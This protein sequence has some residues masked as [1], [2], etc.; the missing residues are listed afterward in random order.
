MSSAMTGV[1]TRRIKDKFLP[2]SFDLLSEVQP[3]EGWFCIVGIKGKGDVRQKLL[4]TRKEADE[5]IEQFVAQQR[6]VFF[7]VAKYKTGDNRTKS[8]VQAL[9]SL[10]VDIDC[11]PEKATP[12]PNTG[13]PAGYA[14]QKEAL[15]A[16][17]DFS[18]LVG[19]P[20]P[21]TVN[22]GCG[23]HAYWVLKEAVTREQWEPVA[24]KLAAVC[25]TQR[26]HVD[27]AVFEAARILRVPGTFNYKD[28]P[29]KAV[30]VLRDKTEKI[31]LEEIMELIG[32]DVEAI[33]QE[34][35][36]QLPVLASAHPDTL[37]NRANLFAALQC[38]LADCD[39]EVYRDTVWAILS[40]GW[41]D[42]EDIALRWCMTA[43][44]RFEED[45]FQ[46]LV[47]SFD[48]S[49]AQ[50]PTIGTIFYFAQRGGFDG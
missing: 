21:V 12:D 45:N 28:D 11:G 1:E 40:T 41:S 50:K 16:L 44:H 7:G 15:A 13:I 42:A 35:A 49:R 8:N 4:E 37:R 47:N 32:V 24:D 14:T 26:F 3:T 30:V 36:P 43:P 27:P 20:L 34:E 31:P 46:S 39:Y 22:S 33:A 2:G 6:N 38:I 48:C 5:V 17:K 9:K 23:I 29:P 10:W 19:L 18:E 25:K